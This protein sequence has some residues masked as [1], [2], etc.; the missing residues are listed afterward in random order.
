[1]QPIGWRSRSAKTSRPSTSPRSLLCGQRTEQAAKKKVEEL[2]KH[3][4]R[5]ERRQKRHKTTTGEDILE[6]Q[7]GGT[8]VSSDDD[9]S[10]SGDDDAADAARQESA[11]VE[12]LALK[13][14]LVKARRAAGMQTNETEQAEQVGQA[15]QTAPTVAQHARAGTSRVWMAFDRKTNRCT[16]PHP[17]DP[18]RICNA[19]PTR[20]GGTSGHRSHPKLVHGPEWTH[21]LATGQRKTTVEMISDALVAQVNQSKPTLGNAG[22]D[23]LHRLAALWVSKHGRP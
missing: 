9:D 18:T 11:A 2:E 13:Q 17:M 1:M 19:P 16:L 6:Q 23:E 5:L 15:E 8:G 4:K 12:L 20:G 7:Q 10:G 22:R 21:I 14:Q 3:K